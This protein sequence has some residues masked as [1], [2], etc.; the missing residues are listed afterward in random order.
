LDLFHSVLNIPELPDA[1]VRL[2]HL[3]FR[4]FLVD[5][6]KH[7]TNPFWVDEKGTHRKMDEGK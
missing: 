1:P 4:D 6:G 3:S 2:L 7:T 5:P